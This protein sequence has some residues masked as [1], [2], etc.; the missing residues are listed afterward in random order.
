[1]R[2]REGATAVRL[3]RGPA[4]RQRPPRLPPRARARVQGHLPALQDDARASTS[5]ARA[6]GTATACRSRSRSSSSSASPP[7]HD[8]ERYGIAEFN[9]KCRESRVRVPRGLDAADRADRL[10]GRPRRPLPHARQRLRRVGLVG[11]QAAVGQATC[12]TRAT[13]SSRTARAAARRSPP[14]RSRRATRTSRTRRV[15]VQL[16]GHRAGRRAARGRRAA[17]LDDDAVDAGLQ[18]RGRGRPRARPTCARTGRRTCW[19]RRSSSACSART[20]RSPTAS[21]ARDMLGA[22]Y[23]PP[24]PFIAGEEYGEKGHTVLPGDFVTAEDGTGIVH[25]AIAFGEDDFRLGAEQGLNVVNPVRPD[26]TYD[27]RIGPYAGPLRQG[28]RRRPD[29]GPAR[30][31][32]AAAAPSAYCTPTRT[33]G[34][35][36]RRCSTTPSRPGTSAPRSCATGCW[37]PTRRSTGTREHI[38][39]GRF[40]K[41][42]G[43]QRRLGAL[44]RALLGHAAADLALRGRA[45]STAIGSFAELRGARRACELDDPHRPFVD[46]VDVR[47]AD[48]VRRAAMRRVPEVIDVWFDSGAMPFAQWHA[49]FENQE[50]VRARASRPTTS[51]RRSTRRAAG[52]TRCSRSRRCC[53]TSSPYKTVLCLGHI[54][55]AEGKKMSKSLGQHRRAVGRHRPPR[56]RRVPLVL[57]HLQAAVGRLPASRSTRSASRC[58]SSCCS[59]GTRTA[60]TCCTR[61]STA[62]SATPT[63]APANDLDRWALS[64]LAATVETVTRAAR[65]LR[66]HARRPGDRGVRR[67]PLELVRAPLAPALLGRRPGRVRDAAHLP[68]DGRA[69]AR[70]VHARS[71]PTR[72]TTT[73]TAPSRAC[74]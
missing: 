42:A 48:A 5:S 47:R 33:A 8:I 69:A 25:T 66:R 18:R 27:E 64:R 29:R 35:A 20:P 38:K 34:A 59:C 19:P 12:S 49:P 4:D 14:T 13:R 51:A 9:A 30:A 32:A 1:M 31:R 60:S 40:G 43:E 58:A 50:H 67:R 53:S 61:T 17:G 57:P 15:Y 7:R 23:E 74:T 2:R 16:P 28:R 6:A 22:R 10:L 70:A 71:S 65:R 72:S 46:D 36:A 68:G 26:G 54:A 44:A 24:F 21:T 63:P 62:S 73:S 41:L 52:S 55:D 37:P 39:H 45:T 3:L 56:R 11:A